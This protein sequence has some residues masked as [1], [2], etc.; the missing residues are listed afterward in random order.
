MNFPVIIL[1]SVSALAALFSYFL[2]RSERAVI[3]LLFSVFSI[4][5]SLWALNLGLF[6]SSNSLD[7]A[8]YYANFYYIAAAAIP[9]LFYYFALYF[10]RRESLFKKSSLVYLIPFAAIIGSILFD[11]NFLILEV[12]TTFADKD[13]ILNITNY[14]I[15]SAYFVLYVLMSYKVLFKTYSTSRTKEEKR[16][17]GYLIFG[18]A[19][20]YVIGMAFNL[21]LPAIGNYHLIWVGPLSILLMV[22][23][24][25]YSIIR[26]RL[27][28]IKAVATELFVVLL[29]L[30]LLIRLTLSDDM[31]EQIA[32]GAILAISIGI[33][34]LLI[35]SVIKEVE[36]RKKIEKLAENLEHANA[37]LV[38]LDRQKDQFLSIASHQFRSPLTAI[39]GYGSLIL[40]GSFGEIPEKIREPIDR[41]FKSADNLTLI[42][43][44]F[45]NISRIEQGRMKYNFEDVDIREMVKDVYD[46]Q[47]P[48]VEGKG[49]KL[50]F[51]ASEHDTYISTVDVG[52]IRQVIINFID[53][54][55]KYTPKGSVTV[56]VDKAN[57]K[58]LVAIKDTGVGI[59]KENIGKLFKL[60]SRTKNAHKVNVSGTGLGL[61]VAKQ[62]V[63]AHKGR[64]WVESPGEG[65]GST[66]FMELNEKK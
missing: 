53:N 18:T 1:F 42:V 7:N 15:Y 5:T 26:H 46:Q 66:F 41:I 34:I 21:I 28:N 31:S 49:L 8:L 4:S 16:K 44:D 13:V 29:W 55:A 40:E 57:G 60:F 58:I 6:L 33:G 38:E 12:F 25:G 2:L 10:G 37:K 63:E 59:S 47:K 48:V 14:Y 30:S 20:A 61:Y 11:K 62:M 65:K 50:A 24:V 36:T 3:N 17:L 56:K 22:L 52:K 9:V 64:I 39:K 45:L 43:E 23:S 27:F 35:R 32:N 19:I 51:E 54:S